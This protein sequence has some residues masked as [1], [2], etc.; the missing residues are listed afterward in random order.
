MN[1]ILKTTTPYVRDGDGEKIDRTRYARHLITSDTRENL[2]TGE[3]MTVVMTIEDCDWY[4]GTVDDR[5]E[6]VMTPDEAIE[7]A[8][9]LLAHA[10][11][12]DRRNCE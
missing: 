11:E 10:R 3:E 9:Q 1:G 4:G 12:A 8:I 7:M 5:R 2:V 6:V